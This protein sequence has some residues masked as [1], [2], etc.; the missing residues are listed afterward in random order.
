[1]LVVT[2]PTVEG[3]PVKQYIGMV[4]GE[5]IAGVN[6]F[7]DFGANLSNM[8]GG[9]AVQQP[10]AGHARARAHF[11]DRACAGDGRQHA[12]GGAGA[13]GHGGSAHFGCD[14]ASGGQR[15]AFRHV[16]LGVHPRLG[17][18]RHRLFLTRVWSPA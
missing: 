8:F 11:Q 3:A 9:R 4:S 14:G 17:L 2:T 18:V 10:Q 13:S 15:F 12:Q 7:K 1:M 6:M 16:V 5:A